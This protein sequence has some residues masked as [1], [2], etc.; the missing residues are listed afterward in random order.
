MPITELSKGELEQLKDEDFDAYSKSLEEGTEW[1]RP[2]YLGEAEKEDDKQPE[3]PVADDKKPEEGEGE[4][5]ETEKKPESE[6]KGKD[7]DGAEDGEDDDIDP[8]DREIVTSQKPERYVSYDKFKDTRDT[9]KKNHQDEVDGLK[10]AIED[11]KKQVPASQQEQAIDAEITAFAGQFNVP[12]D[13]VKGMMG[14]MKKSVGL[15]DEQRK[16]LE[17]A[18]VARHNRDQVRSFNKDF[19]LH[20]LPVLTQEGKS[21]AQIAEIRAK[22]RGYKLNPDDDSFHRT[23]LDVIYFGKKDF[24][25]ATARKEGRTTVEEGR[26]AG[27]GRQTGVSQH[28]EK[29]PIDGSRELTADEIRK[30]SDKEFDEYSDNM[31]KVHRG[32]IRRKGK[33]G[34]MSSVPLSKNRVTETK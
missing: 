24:R 10:K 2:D 19:D 12:A 6:S 9:L 18:R 21:E 14:I 1:K 4:E 28:D 29:P 23:P 16:D 26:G 3:T 20:L 32:T 5:E 31:A 34:K 15:T 27:A 30:L 13:L 22:V 25:A 8:A 17:D 33:D 7:Q 11:L